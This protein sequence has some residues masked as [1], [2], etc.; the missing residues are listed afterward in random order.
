MQ[1]QSL[2]SPRLKTKVLDLMRNHCRVKHLSYRTEQTYCQWVRRFWEF[3]DRKTLYD[4]GQEEIERYLTHLAV[5]RKVSASTQNQA[6][7][8]LVF[9]YK[10][11]VPK[12]LGDIDAVRAKRSCRIPSVFSRREVQA[13]FKHLQGTEWMMASLL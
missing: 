2:H 9:L 11:V 5:V 13:I 1:G 3:N 10:Y 7:N 6:F 8:A 12:D 4:A